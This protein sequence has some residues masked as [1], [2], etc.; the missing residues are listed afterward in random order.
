M[1]VKQVEE[2]SLEYFY[3][4]NKKEAEVVDY[5]ASK[6]F[7]DS[8]GKPIPWKIQP[9]SAEKEAAIR[10][11]S[12]ETKTDR[13]TGVINEVFHDQAYTVAITAA[14]VVF[15]PLTDVGIQQSYGVRG[16]GNLLRKMLTAGELQSLA[17]KVIEVSGLDDI[18]GQKEDNE[19]KGV[20]AKNS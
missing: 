1:S 16:E 13:R 17:L 12:T 14:S 5:I 10:E 15:P 7:V 2:V 4:Q 20:I 6:S 9:L 19:L 11:M 3:Q 8:D 18:E